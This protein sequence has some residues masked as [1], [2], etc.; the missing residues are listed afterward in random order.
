MGL[1]L[2]ALAA[3][4]A[5]A[6]VIERVLDP[7]REKRAFLESVAS[8]V[9]VDPIAD[10]GGMHDAANW[11]LRRDVV[12]ALA[13]AVSATRFFAANEARPRFLLGDRENLDRKGLP[14]GLQVLIEWPRPLTT[15]LVVLG[16]TRP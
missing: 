2:V 10:Y 9:G 15:D 4:V 16:P 13:D 3:T 8:V 7:G 14:A 6:R 1:A 5:Q 12:P 11:A